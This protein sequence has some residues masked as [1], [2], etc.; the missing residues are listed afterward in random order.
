MGIGDSLMT[1]LNSRIPHSLTAKDISSVNHPEFRGGN[2]ITGGDSDA[3]SVGNLLKFYNRDVC[4]LSRGNTSL[5]Y[6][7]GP[8][9]PA[10]SRLV[11][12]EPESTGLNAAQSGAWTTLH[13]LY[14]QLKYLDLYYNDFTTKSME[15]P[16]K[17]IFVELGFNNICLGCVSWAKNLEFSADHYERHLRSLIDALRIRYKNAFVTLMGPFN[18]SQVSF[19]FFYFFF[20]FFLLT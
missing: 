18:V 7:Y 4:G 6:C 16:W 20:L 12:F 19:F 10:G 3:T 5:I 17:L 11:P 15:E 13:N 9:C 8:V 1:G 2:F 14:N